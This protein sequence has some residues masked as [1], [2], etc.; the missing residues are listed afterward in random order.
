VNHKS[1]L[2][3]IP[4][5]RPAFR[6]IQSQQNA[7]SGFQINGLGILHGRRSTFRVLHHSDVGIDAA[8]MALYHEA[9]PSDGPLVDRESTLS[10][11]RL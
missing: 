4:L 11:D 2:Q 3:G 1:S 5:Q 9:M 7:A 6:Q 10:G 8:K